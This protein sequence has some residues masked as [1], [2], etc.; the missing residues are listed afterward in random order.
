MLLISLLTALKVTIMNKRQVPT[1]HV[2]I[3][4]MVLIVMLLHPSWSM[5]NLRH[6]IT[7]GPDKIPSQILNSSAHEIAPSLSQLFNLSITSGNV[8][9]DWKLAN[10]I[11]V[12]KSGAKNVY[13]NYRPISVTSTVSKV[14]EKIVYDKILEHLNATGKIPKDQHGFLSRRSCSTI[15]LDTID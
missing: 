10:V 4:L 1:Y 7:P 5:K 13:N 2:I 12:F 14:L 8:P 9:R 3:M 6:N 15:H 11:P